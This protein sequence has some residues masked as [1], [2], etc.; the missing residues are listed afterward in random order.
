MM[1]RS[2]NFARVLVGFVALASACALAAGIRD[3]T[4]SDL[5]YVQTANLG[6]IIGRNSC[7]LL[8]RNLAILRSVSSGLMGAGI[9]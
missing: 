2:R 1:H 9:T 3:G 8:L 6:P 5:V 7:H 4:C